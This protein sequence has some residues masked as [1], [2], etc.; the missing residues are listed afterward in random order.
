MALN[1]NYFTGN[2]LWW[3]NRPS[4]GCYHCWPAGNF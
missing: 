1:V 4:V 2:R 3:P